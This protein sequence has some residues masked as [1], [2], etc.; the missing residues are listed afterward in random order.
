MTLKDL[1]YFLTVADLNS[2]TKASSALF[3]AQPALS[4]S[5]KKLEKEVGSVLFYRDKTGSSLTDEGKFFYTFAQ[6]VLN[7]KSNLDMKIKELKNNDVKDTRLGFSGTLAST[8]LLYILQDFKKEHPDIRIHLIEAWGNEAEEK[9]ISRE[10]DLAIMPEPVNSNKLDYFEFFRDDMVVLPSP[11]SNYQKYVYELEGKQEPY[12]SMDFFRSN[13]IVTTFPGQ[14]TRIITD[15]MFE[16]SGITPIISLMARNTATL[17]ALALIDIASCIVPRRL[18]AK[19]EDDLY[20][21]IPPEFSEPYIYIAATLKD[22]YQSAATH[23]LIESIKNH[24]IHIQSDMGSRSW[25]STNN[26][27]V[28]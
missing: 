4:Q 18:L 1:E 5:M 23:S 20:F 2:I 24:E 26:T 16:R 12:I 7:E 15:N 8:I 13:P 21:K 28:Y 27:M 9:L 11:S 19:G 14:R 6:N 10:I 3:I 25:D 22:A 17:K